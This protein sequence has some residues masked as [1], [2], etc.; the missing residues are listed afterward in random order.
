MKKLGLIGGTSWHSTI[1]YYRLINELSANRLGDGSNPPLILYSLNIAIMRTMNTDT[2]SAEYISIAK[3]LELA[4]AE[5]III[6][7]N[8]PHMI[9]PV[10]VPRVNIPIL[11]IADAMAKEA[12]KLNIS[13]LG[14]LGT[15]ATMEK[16]FL[17]DRLRKE[18]GLGTLTPGMNARE[19][20]NRIISEE[21]TRGI[22][23]NEA[24][25]Y[26]TGEM[27]KL[28]L[29]GAEGIILGCTELPLL[30]KPEDF[31]LPLLNTTLL[32]AEMAVEFIFSELAL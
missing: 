27:A 13:K 26:M 3:K 10:L 4:G 21:L 15:R 9:Y 2:I 6:C 7:A 5:A 30:I 25:S 1:D 19:E 16:D 14:L 12:H 32:H 11:H 28:K 8:T 20:I 23:T 17:K 18:H 31:D 29:Q 22:F 24:K